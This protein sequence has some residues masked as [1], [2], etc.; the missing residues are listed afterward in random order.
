MRSLPK[1]AFLLLT[2]VLLA[3]GRAGA[4]GTVE[5]ETRSIAR[6]AGERLCRVAN[7]LDRRLSGSGLRPVSRTAS[8]EEGR[9]SLSE[10][11][12]KPFRPL[13]IEEV[14]KGER[15]ELSMANPGLVEYRLKEAKGLVNLA[16]A[17]MDLRKQAATRGVE[18]GLG[19]A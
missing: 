19:S 12:G 8:L 5:S 11:L 15:E 16:R 7:G 17:S 2:G 18:C 3:S 1:L 13:P 14:Q 9:R 10:R 4:S 6:E